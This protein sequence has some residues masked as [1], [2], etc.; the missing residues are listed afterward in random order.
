MP[1]FYGAIDIQK[2]ELRQAVVQNL[3]FASA[4][5]SPGKG[6]LWFDST[7]NI[8]KW[9][10]GGTW[11]SAMG[12][13]GAVAA[14]TVTTQAIGDAPVSGA[15]TLYS[16]GDHK[17][18]EPAFGAITAET[19][20]G[21]ASGNGA[22]ATLARSGH[23]HGN[24]THHAAAHSAIPLSALAVPTADVSWNSKK[25]T[26][27][28]DPTGA[29]DGATKNYVD[30]VAQGLDAKP[31]VKV[32]SIGL[33]ITLSGTTSI[34]GIAVSAGE[35]VLVKDQTNQT[36]NGIYVCSA[37]PWTRAPDA[38]TW[39][40]LVSAF[41]F[42][43]MGPTNQD[44]GWV[45]TANV[46]GT[47]GS[48]NNSWTQFSAAGAVTAGAGLTKTGNT[49]D[50]IPLDSTL[51]VAADSVAVNTSVIATQTYVNT[52]VTGLA[53]KFAGA[54]T[55]TV[56]PEVI[57]HNLNTRDVQVTVLNGASPYTAV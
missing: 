20:F 40:E 50:V 2:N 18:G 1:V 52:A 47:L 16:R 48:T 6:Q 10:D 33:N 44:T 28:L 55:G 19:A 43:E 57:T 26:S 29:Q 51:V 56:S 13:A 4:P 32:A 30:S 7:N 5:S 21:T 15:S 17:H 24:P 41:T 12:G 8:L 37:G 38:D 3:A 25:I 42:V 35:R 34:D 31:S 11:V 27:L 9:W 46:G 23:T 49:I 39:N 45:C 14:D 54:V 53:K 22:A 36:E